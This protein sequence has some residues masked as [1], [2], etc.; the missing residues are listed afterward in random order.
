MFRIYYSQTIKDFNGILISVESDQVGE[1]ATDRIIAK[2]ADTDV[3][4]LALQGCSLFRMNCSQTIQDFSSK[5]SWTKFQSQQ[6]QTE[7]LQILQ[8]HCSEKIDASRMFRMN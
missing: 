5:V 3:R 8:T 4:E 7:L 6:D 1:S 2:L